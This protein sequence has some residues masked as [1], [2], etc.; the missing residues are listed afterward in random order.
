MPKI[1]TP[2]FGNSFEQYI[3]MELKAYQAYKNPELDIYYWRTSTGFEVDFILG[4][5]SAAIEVKSSQRIH[6]GHIRGM[7]ALLE[8][9]KV[10]RAIIVSLEKYPRKLE[11]NIEVLPWQVFLESLWSGE[12]ISINKENLAQYIIHNSLFEL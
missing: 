4:N 2:E 12:R 5:M 10:K 8:E 3:L 1:G 11:K 9:H 7:K 6:S